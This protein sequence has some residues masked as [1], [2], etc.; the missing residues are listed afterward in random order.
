VSGTLFLLA[1]YIGTEGEQFG[2]L[3]RA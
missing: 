1:N 2:G 3:V